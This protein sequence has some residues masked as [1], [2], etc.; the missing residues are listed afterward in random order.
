[1]FLWITGCQFKGWHISLWPRFISWFKKM[2]PGRWESGIFNF[3]AG[4]QIL[5]QSMCF[6]NPW[7]GFKYRVKKKSMR[8]VYYSYSSCAFPIFCD[9]WRITNKNLMVLFI[10]TIFPEMVFRVLYIGIVLIIDTRVSDLS[11]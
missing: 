10:H 8:N 2:R 6:Q 1:M 11:Y 5:L 9:V 7:I 4:T 3:C